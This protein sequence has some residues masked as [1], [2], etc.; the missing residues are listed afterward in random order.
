VRRLGARRQRDG[1]A[2]REEQGGAAEQRGRGPAGG[3][4]LGRGAHP[5]R[6]GA[7]RQG[8]GREGGEA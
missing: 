7:Q 3:A 2:D 6:V 4:V 8:A 1:G 5:A